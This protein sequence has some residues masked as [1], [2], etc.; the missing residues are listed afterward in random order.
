[1]Q[2]STEQV[3]A[4][5]TAIRKRIG[6]GSR[7]VALQ[8]I[9]GWKGPEHLE[10]AGEDHQVIACV[11]D[12]QIR[13]AL[14]QLESQ[15]RPGILLC[16]FDS[17]RLGED[18]LARLAKRRIYH[19]QLEEMLCELFS[20]RL[21]DGRVLTCKPLV[22][23][24]IRGASESAYIPAAGGVLDLD[25]A[26]KALLRNVLKRDVSEVTFLDLLR[27]TTQP[28]TRAALL[29]MNQEV[30]GAFAH[31]LAPATSDAARQLFR[32]FETEIGNDLVAMGLLFG[33]LGTTEKRAPA[34][35]KAA[36]ARLEQYFGNEMVSAGARQVWFQAAESILKSLTETEVFQAKDVL[37]NL[38]RLIERVRLSEHASLSNF[39]PKGLEQRLAEAADLLLGAQ[40]SG[41]NDFQKVRE[42]LDNAL[43]HALAP[44]EGLRVRR[45]QMALRLAV[46][47]NSTELKTDRTFSQLV[48]DYYTEGGF[49]DWARN[50]I[51]ESDPNPRVKECLHL[52]LQRADD[53]WSAFEAAFI[54][55]LQQWTE[56]DGELQQ[57]E[58]IE[59][60][61]EDVVATVAK[62]RPALLIVLDGMSMA[63]FRELMADVLRRNWVETT[64]GTTQVRPVVAT[65]PSITEISRRA[66]LRG[67]LNSSREGSEKTDFAKNEKLIAK[68]GSAAKPQLF[69]KGDL[70][71]AGRPGLSS[72][73][74]EAITNTRC[75]L[76]G[77]V[78]NAIDDTLGSADQTS[79][80]WSLDQITPLHE[81]MQLAAEAGRVVVLTSDHGHVL[82]GGSDLIKQPWDESGDRHRRAG[83]SL[84]E[85]ELEF[86]G[87]RIRAA[88]GADSVVVL[89]KQRA[90]YQGKRRGYHG[91]VA[92]SEMIVPC[93]ILRNIGTSVT[94]EWMDLPPYEP[95]WWSLRVAV[96]GI[97]SKPSAKADKSPRATKPQGELFEAR[98]A[99][100]VTADWIK[101]FFDSEVYQQQ[102]RQTVRGALPVKQ[103]KGFLVLMD[104]RNGRL[105][106]GALAQQLEL[107]LLRV[108]GLIQNY[109]RLFNVDG[110]DV[111]SYDQGSE[112]VALNIQL[113][114]SQFQL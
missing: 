40:Q 91:G 9:G 57:V 45:L 89:G 99:A 54:Q 85:G 20:A 1:M 69:L 111:L 31:W 93:V 67:S 26:W 90:R 41:A 66:L 81:L 56:Q 25:S 114:K 50:T 86:K 27:W 47:R 97:E 96:Q 78:V 22:D 88:I 61:L 92:P 73:V 52:A 13:E 5:A 53:A 17:T 104:E 98:V 71:E 55:R 42:A 112:T 110:Y 107:P 28:S 16:S 30:R 80:A 68:M 58:R 63:V 35:A 10:V 83:G 100:P 15:D 76:V 101:R 113:L 3:R 6:S 51:A 19:P 65:V 37:H 105:L 12:L 103:L 48:H 82:D 32:V 84:V 109:R 14:S 18:V 79:Y 59:D 11:S 87:T 77:V 62:A 4:Q 39:S 74:T 70:L 23:A 49:I 24:L 72:N 95:E 94:E 46:W 106:R 44:S 29:G 7:I 8:H 64:L 75:R 38:D 36:S 108:D 60:V 34:D 21:V 33:L 102:S 2:L 43:Q